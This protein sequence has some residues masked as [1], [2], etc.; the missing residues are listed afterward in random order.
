MRYIVAALVLLIACL[1]AQHRATALT[2]NEL[3]QSCQTI[4]RTISTKKQP[5]IDIPEAGL[6][7][8]YYMSAM[9]NMSVLVD[10]SGVRLLGVCPPSESTVLDFIRVFVQHSRGKAADVRNAAAL[11]LPGLANAFPCQQATATK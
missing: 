1:L 7:C 5:T 3:L 10:G 2:S 9:Q 4:T 6:A 11:A 8:W